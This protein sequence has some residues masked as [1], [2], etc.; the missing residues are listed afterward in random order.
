M[1]QWQYCKIDL[2]D[3]PTRMSDVELLD[4]AGRDGWELVGITAN[5]FA[6]M[7]RPAGGAAAATPAEAPQRQTVRRRTTPTT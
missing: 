6:Y 7:K 3:M 4:E 1:P 5:N 2:S